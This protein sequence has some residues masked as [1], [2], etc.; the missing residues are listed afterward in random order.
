MHGHVVAE[1]LEWLSREGVIGAF[2][3]LQANNVGLPLHEPA[4]QVVHALADGIDVP[5][6]NTHGF[7][8]SRRRI[9]RIHRVYLQAQGYAPVNVYMLGQTA[10]RGPNWLEKQA[11]P[12]IR[13]RPGRRT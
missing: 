11:I 7:W 13:E 1:R 4:L 9:R 8:G 2:D 5:G 12:R 10:T 6:G 3:L